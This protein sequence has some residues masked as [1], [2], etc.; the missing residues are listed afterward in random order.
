MIGAHSNAPAAPPATSRS[1]GQRR[2]ERGLWR[3]ADAGTFPRPMASARPNLPTRADV[4]V[5]GAGAVGAATAWNLTERAGL[6]VAMIEARAVAAGSTSRSAA[7]F[8][9]QFSSRAHVRMSLFSR[10]VYETFPETFGGAPVFVRNGY[11]FLY[12]DEA[13]MAAA[14]KG[15]EYQRAEGVS[16]VVALTSAGVD[17]LPGLSGAFRTDAIVGA[18]WCPSDGFLRP[19][20]IA[21]GFVEGAK[22]RGAT[23]HVGAKVTAIETSGSRVSAVVLDGRHRI[24]TRAVVV[25]A[26]WWSNA[27]SSLAGCPI[28]VVAVKRYLYLTP[29]FEGRKVG[30]FPLVVW[31]LGAYARPEGNGLMMGW[32]DR[33]KRPEGSDRFPPP[34]QDVVELEDR[35]DAIAPGFGKG[36]D[37]YGIEVLAQLA[38][39]MPWLEDEGGVQYVA[40]GYYEVTPDDRAILSEDPRLSGLFHA[41]GFSGHGIMHAPAAGRA[42]ADLVLGSTPPFPMEGFALKPLLDNQPRADR[43]QMII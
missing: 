38:E 18:T 41:S 42:T 39:A 30:H 15:V 26:G 40:G 37:E 43:E 29:Q 12:D 28:P 22:R 31:N 8:R 9:Q 1:H 19:T 11:L 7:A 34:R 2:R 3:S 14:R 24:E 25:A 35:Q 17:A 10:Q 20:E 23:L 33:P 21:S 13:K 16:D 32:D 27:V 36:I 4:V 5:V 6:S